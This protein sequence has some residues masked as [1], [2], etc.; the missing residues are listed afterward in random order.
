MTSSLL[1]RCVLCHGPLHLCVGIRT[2]LIR[3][4]ACG[5]FDHWHPVFEDEQ[6]IIGGDVE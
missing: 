2:I 6:P 4:G 3:C 5:R 1:A